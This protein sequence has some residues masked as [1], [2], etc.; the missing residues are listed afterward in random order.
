[1]SADAGRA[2]AEA[3]CEVL[4]DEQA[5]I[6]DQFDAAGGNNEIDSLESTLMGLGASVQALAELNTYFRNLPKVASSEIETEAELVADGYKKLLDDAKES[7][8]SRDPLGGIV[9]GAFG[10]LQMSGPLNELGNYAR[11]K[12]G[13]NI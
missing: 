4:E 7:A 5:R 12:C 2:V 9:R 13:R 3:F 11:D 8:A 6:L 10:S 1:M